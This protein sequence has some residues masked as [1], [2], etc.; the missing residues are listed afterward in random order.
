MG[1]PL[2][3][4]KKK[5]LEKKKWLSSNARSAVGLEGSM[6]ALD[7]TVLDAQVCV[8]T[9]GRVRIVGAARRAAPGVPG[10]G[11]LWS[12]RHSALRVVV[13]G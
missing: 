9:A 11:A 7:R 5:A 2:W 10:S 3:A 1:S 12:K 13:S 4:Q 6:A 8:Q